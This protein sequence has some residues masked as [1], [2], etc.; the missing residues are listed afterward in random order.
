MPQEPFQEHRAHTLH[1]EISLKPS[2][3]QPPPDS[4]IHIPKPRHRPSP[5]LVQTAR[6]SESKQWRE[7]LCENWRE[8][9][10]GKNLALRE[11]CVEKN[12]PLREKRVGK[13]NPRRET[14]GKPQG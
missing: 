13:K 11:K 7:K 10:V 3:E 5:R 9:C 6:E 12:S 4:S 1:P 14:G 2:E 8:K